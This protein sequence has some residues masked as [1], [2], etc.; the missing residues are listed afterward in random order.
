MTVQLG[1][2]RVVAV[3]EHKV[4]LSLTAKDLDQVHQV[5]VFQL[6]HRYKAKKNKH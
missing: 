1:K 6:L 3:L 2:D 5:G 4:K